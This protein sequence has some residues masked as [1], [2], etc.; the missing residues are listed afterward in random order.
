MDWVGIDT[1]AKMLEMF[2]ITL[3]G[4]A[5]SCGDEGAAA[6][7][8]APE[9]DV[10][11][12]VRVGQRQALHR[13]HQAHAG[14]VDHHVRPAPGLQ[15]R[16]GQR[17][18]GRGVGHVAGLRQAVGAAGAQLGDHGVQPLGNVHV[19]QQ[20]PRA[21]R[22]QVA[23]QRLTDAGGGPGDHHALAFEGFHGGDCGT[24]GP[25]RLTCTTVDLQQQVSAGQGIQTGG[26]QRFPDDLEVCHEK[27]FIYRIVAAC[28]RLHRDLRPDGHLARR[29][30]QHDQHT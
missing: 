2:T 21:L 5:C 24:G 30:G 27:A 4:R 12:P 1:M 16:V 13:R 9:V 26:Q 15:R 25:H 20:Q 10:H 11:E 23:R 18:H 8:H 6:V 29:A 7:H 14:V 17:L 22:G 3:P 28:T 19:G